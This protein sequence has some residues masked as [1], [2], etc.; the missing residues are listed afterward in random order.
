MRLKNSRA[1]LKKCVKKAAKDDFQGDFF[2]DFYFA[3]GDYND[4]VP[5]TSEKM[6]STIGECHEKY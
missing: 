5:G 4:S 1:K 2:K 6:D 3:Q